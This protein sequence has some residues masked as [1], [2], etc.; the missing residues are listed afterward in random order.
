MAQEVYDS[1]SDS[2]Y[3]P[4]I[5]RYALLTEKHW[6]EWQANQFAACLIMPRKSVLGKLILWQV[7]E[8]IRNRGKVYLD[9]QPDNIRNFKVMITLLAYEF[10]VSRTILE[11]R[12]NDLEIITYANPKKFRSASLFGHV[13]QAQSLSDILARI[14]YNREV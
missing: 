9:H 13:R 7:T 1:Q 12:M 6:I 8:G 2:K 4:A 3:D 11:Y 10:K 5:R 14:S